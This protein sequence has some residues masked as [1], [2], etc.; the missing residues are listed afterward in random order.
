M[1][2]VTYEVSSVFPTE[3]A[4]GLVALG[5]VGGEVEVCYRGTVMRARVLVPEGVKVPDLR[6]IKRAATQSV[7]KEKA[8]EVVSIKIEEGKVYTKD[9]LEA[10]SA[11]QLK[12]ATGLSGKRNEVIQKYLATTAPAVDTEVSEDK[13]ED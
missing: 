4:A 7:V 1:S 5:A 9:E 2:K 12:K 10:M 8:P 6:V 3:F 11:G 13:A